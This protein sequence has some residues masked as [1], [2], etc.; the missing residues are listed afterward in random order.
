[1]KNKTRSAVSK[2]K[3][4]FSKIGTEIKESFKPEEVVADEELKEVK[5]LTAEIGELAEQANLWIDEAIV[6]EYKDT[7]G[8]PVRSGK[9]TKTFLKWYDLNYA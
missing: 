1:M 9:Y 3:N 8:I 7:G 5:K 6:Q 2:V 4:F